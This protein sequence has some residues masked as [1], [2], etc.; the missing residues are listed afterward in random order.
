MIKDVEGTVKHLKEDQTYPAT[1]AELV[2]ACNEL[3]DF[4][5]SDKKTF[6][7][8]L[9]D[10]TYYSAEEVMKTLGIHQPASI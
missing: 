6:M 10:K 7:E 2:A 1:K 4:G 3:S 8:S 5:E 9:S